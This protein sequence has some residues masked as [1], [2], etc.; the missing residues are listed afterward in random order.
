M[1]QVSGLAAPLAYVMTLSSAVA[2][3]HVLAEVR[4]G[5]RRTSAILASL[6]PRGIRGARAL[7]GAHT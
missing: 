5:L 1:P 4:P 7:P 3:Y 6:S 2:A